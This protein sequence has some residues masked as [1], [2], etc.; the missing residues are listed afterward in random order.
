MAEALATK[1]RPREWDEVSSQTSIRR[2]LTRQ[3]ELD[4]LK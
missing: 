4:E 1:Y 2:I 3:I